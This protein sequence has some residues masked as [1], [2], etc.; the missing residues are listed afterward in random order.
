MAKDVENTRSLVGYTVSVAPVGTT[1]PTDNT[2]ALNSA[3]VEIGYIGDSG[4]N[5]GREGDDTPV[6]DAAGTKVRTFR[7][8]QA[9]TFTFTAL[10]DTA[11]RRALEEPGAD[12][13]TVGAMSVEDVKDAAPARKAMVLTLEDTTP[14][15]DDH[16]TRIV[17]P[18]AEIVPGEAV[19]VDGQVEGIEFTCSTVKQST[20]THYYRYSGETSASVP[21]IVSLSPTSGDDGGGELVI[22]TGAHFTGTTG[23][24]FDA[25]AV[26]DFTVLSD[27]QL[28]VVTP[29]GTAGAADVVVTNATGA[30]TTGTGDFTYTA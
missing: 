29:A 1:L 20:G 27:T 9:R 4:I 14:N 22:I 6:Y 2:S 12:V 8:R 30:S 13:S 15:G 18:E 21:E 16:V 26:G 19:R 7:A 23:V 17:I 25:V 11:T 24:T 3:F 5:R 28:A 10:E